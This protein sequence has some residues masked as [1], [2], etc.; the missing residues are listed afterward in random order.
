M[1]FKIDKNLTVRKLINILKQEFNLELEIL[2]GKK[3]LRNKITTLEVNRPGIAL[4]GYFKNFAFSR[5]QLFGRGESDYIISLKNDKRRSLL[6]QFFSYKIPCCFFVDNKKPDNIFIQLTNKT[7]TPLITV[8]LNTRELNETLHEILEKHYSPQKSLHGVMVEVSG[9][10][11]LILGKSGVG[12][13]E[14][15]LELITRGHRLIGDDVVIVNKMGGSMLI[16]QGPDLIKYHIEIRGVGIIDIQ[17]LY[18]VGSV[19]ERKR[20]DIVVI[21]EEWGQDKK[22][23]RIGIDDKYYTILG[24]KIPLIELPVKP[25]RN[26]PVIIE[27]AALNIRLRH[28]GVHSSFLLN[29]KIKDKMKRLK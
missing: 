16:A 27:T 3:G 29:K 13:S 1:S 28:M 5:I 21:L 12:K 22:Y 9:I 4:A 7:N 11:V 2:S 19:R 26:I 25:G 18:G 20:I 6:K 15:A 14:C 10:G 17:R 23:E 24:V 8:N